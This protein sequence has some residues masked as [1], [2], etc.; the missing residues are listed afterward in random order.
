MLAFKLQRFCPNIPVQGPTGSNRVKNHWPIDPAHPAGLNSMA[1]S[2]SSP[3]VWLNCTE[4]PL[5][6]DKLKALPFHA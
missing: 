3:L 6:E 1:N 2:I 4:P 5:F